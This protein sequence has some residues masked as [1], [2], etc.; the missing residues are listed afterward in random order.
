MEPGWQWTGRFLPPFFASDRTKLRFLRLV[1]HHWPEDE[2]EYSGCRAYAICRKQT[3]PDLQAGDEKS[4]DCPACE[5]GVATRNAAVAYFVRESK[6]GSSG[7]GIKFT[8]QNL[9]VLN[10]LLKEGCFDFNKGRRVRIWVNETWKLD[11]ECLEADPVDQKDFEMICGTGDLGYYKK[12]VSGERLR[13]MANAR[14]AWE[15]VGQATPDEGA[16]RRLL[17]Q[18][19]ASTLIPIPW[20]CKGPV[21]NT[22]V[23]QLAKTD[24][25]QQRGVVLDYVT[26]NSGATN[27]AFQGDT[28]YYISDIVFLSGTNTLEGGAVLKFAATNT[29]QIYGTVGAAL[30]CQ[31]A[32]YRPAILTALDDDSVGEPISGS[33]GNPGGHY[34]GAGLNWSENITLHDLRLSYMGTGIFI[35]GA[36]GSIRNVQFGNCYYSVGLVGCGAQRLQN[37]LIQGGFYG[38][39]KFIGCPTFISCENVTFHNIGQ[40]AFNCSPNLTNCLI[41][42]VT[43]TG[44]II[45][46]SNAVLSSDAGVF[47]TVGAGSHY[48]ATNCPVGIRNAGTTNIDPGLLTTL[49]QKTTCPPIVYSN[50]VISIAT[51]FSPQAQRDTNSVP[52]LGYHYDPLDY[53]FG[54]TEAISNITF[55]AGTA[56]GWFDPWSPDGYGIIVDNGATVAFNGTAITP[57]WLV[58]YDTS[59][60]GGNG[61]WT[62][63]GYLAGITSNNSN[64]GY[65][66]DA[67]QVV[68]QFTK[69][70]SRNFNDSAFRDRTGFFVLRAS[71]CEFWNAGC[72]GYKV[73]VNYTNCLFFR[74]GPWADSS[75]SS[76]SFTLRNCLVKGCTGNALAV[77][78]ESGANSWP[79]LIVDCTFDETSINMNDYSGGIT[80]ITY[81]DYNAFLTNGSRLAVL[82]LHDVTN[83]ISFNW[84]SN[85]LGN[86]YLPTNSP[87]VDAGSTTANQVGLY[88]FTTQTN[89][90][91][92]TNSPVDIGYHYVALDAR[93]N[94]LDNDSDGVPDW[95]DADPNNPSIGILTIFIDSPANGATLQ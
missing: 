18:L 86:Y 93:G 40:L 78:H 5:A 52:D 28:T 71:N 72:G 62:A 34:Y 23:I 77:L 16:H 29:A 74:I 64:P 85:W 37:V 80:N 6:K 51:N 45:G 68:A 66:S 9:D 84:Q 56:V 58:R 65:T 2:I 20:G 69:F 12:I 11:Y 46:I 95:E 48:L 94:L 36:A 53:V 27:F 76:S 10:R 88:N 79:V 50:I 57:C 33:T 26:M 91:E 17:Q 54:G 22:N 38:I 44:T 49:R 92:E 15:K 81:C 73:S 43:N 87:L 60:E 39:A 24:L 83:I 55:T 32:P 82:G 31:T 63:R 89:Q 3:H 30:I 90:V 59:Q 7:T 75:Q 41:A 13:S 35:S 25:G 42:G 61:N 19:P 8:A 1:T 70:S 14:L 67:S 47:Q 4:S 21:D